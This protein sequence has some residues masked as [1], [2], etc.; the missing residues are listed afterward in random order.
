MELPHSPYLFFMGVG[1]FAIVKDD[2]KGKEVSY[3]VERNFEKVARK[4]FGSTP[5]M[6]GFFSK[7]LGVEYPWIKYSQIVAR[8]YVSGAMENTTATLHSEYLQQ[9][10]RE[11]T[12][13]NKYE[14]YIS[15]EL[16]HQWFGNLVTAE[17]WSNL[18]L[19]ESFATYS[20]VL[21]REYKYGKDDAAAHEY[22][23]L[24][25]Y[26]YSGGAGK[27]LVRFNYRD[28]EDMFDAVSY[29]KGGRILK[30]LRNYVGD[31][32]FFKSLNVYLTTHKFKNAEAHQLRLAFEEVTGKDLNWFFNQWFFGSGHP[33][34]DITYQYD[35]LAGVANVYV[36]QVQENQIFKL[37]FAIDV[38]ENGIKKRYNV[39]MKNKADTFRFSVAQR[40]G[41]INVDADKMLLADKKDNKSL[42]NY[43]EQYRYPRT[44]IDR[45]EAIDYCI[46]HMNKPEAKGLLSEA[47]NDPYH[48]LRES[49]LAAFA[50][51]VAVLNKDDIAIIEN[52]ASKD[53]KKTT[54][55]AA[56]SVLAEIDNPKYKST[57][58]AGTKDSSYSVAGASLAALAMADEALAVSL[59]PQL[60]SDA[61]GRLE[62]AV[63]NVEVFTKGDADYNELTSRFDS[64]NTFEK[65]TEYNWYLNFLSN[66][67]NTENFKKGID[68]IIA[69]R[70]LVGGYDIRYKNKF[71]RQLQK[72]ILKKEKAKTQENTS[73]L[74]LQI[75]YVEEKI[76]GA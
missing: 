43:I 54:R 11:L 28:K 72:V 71:N 3:Y 37:P 10:A 20:E 65:L 70:N 14:D 5:E 30:M 76:K 55:A 21:W 42:R 22:N 73:A 32:A 64:V 34:L 33:Q 50:E 68:R 8:D 9:N 58:L 4:I 60:K 17:S 52:V 61:K 29:Q 59:L 51:D 44:Y 45:K 25:T 49:V 13:G 6:M 15:H 41:L 46:V 27:E 69:F 56:I 12:D 16:F 36:K 57:F 31:S 23:D 38:Y 47:L 53:E 66:V 7:I 40:P 19:N 1:D 63:K 35:S 74:D 62:K 39:V 18:A 67:H 26:L 2:Y 75:Q 24:L 48:G